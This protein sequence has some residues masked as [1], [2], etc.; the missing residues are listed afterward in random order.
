[1]LHAGTCHLE[2][3]VDRALNARKALVLVCLVSSVARTLG[4]PQQQQRMDTCISSYSRLY[5]GIDSDLRHWEPDG[6]SADL[7]DRYV[8]WEIC[9]MCIYYFHGPVW[10]IICNLR[11]EWS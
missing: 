1:M 4:Q 9:H 5:S 7:M 6:I 8:E 3:K 11:R 10:E 2:N